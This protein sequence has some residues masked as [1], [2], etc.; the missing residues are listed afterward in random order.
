VHSSNTFYPPTSI[1]QCPPINVCPP[2]SVRR[3]SS[4]SMHHI[5]QIILTTYIRIRY[6][7]L[8]T[9]CCVKTL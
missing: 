4:S 9:V 1:H 8:Q 3:H 5:F 2:M 7:I 6:H